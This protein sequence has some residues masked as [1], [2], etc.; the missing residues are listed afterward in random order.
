MAPRVAGGAR[1]LMVADRVVGAAATDAPSGLFRITHAEHAPHHA[2]SY[3]PDTLQRRGDT[4][5]L[6]RDRV[7]R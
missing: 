1:V 3:P 4:R 7:R 5:R 2:S 6:R